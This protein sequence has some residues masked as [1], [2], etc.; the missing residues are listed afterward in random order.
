MEESEIQKYIDFIKKYIVLDDIEEKITRG[1]LEEKTY[2]QIAAQIQLSEIEIDTSTLRDRG[3]ILFNKVNKC[4]ER[5][6]ISKRN[7]SAMIN[8]IYSDRQNL[9]YVKRESI[10]TKA[11]SA[12][13]QPASLIRIKA[14]QKMGKTWLLK[15]ILT[16]A[17]ERG[18]TTVVCDFGLFESSRYSIAI[19]NDS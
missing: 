10:E 14:P 11:C 17:R 1:T 4:F 12:N 18:F 5:N 2:D 13:S 19:L 8:Q 16:D 6:D 7:F 9:I 3:S 15:H